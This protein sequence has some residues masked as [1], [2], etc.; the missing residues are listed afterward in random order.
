MN[1]KYKQRGW[2]PDY[3][4]T[5]D[6]WRYGEPIPEWLSDQV[7]IEEISEEGNPIMTE[8]RTNSGYIEIIGSDGTSV[9]VRLRNT[10]S[11]IIY[12]STHP[13]ISLTSHQFEL[14]YEDS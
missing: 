3:P 9:V 2:N 1:L 5:V 7:R 6:V 8:R 13:L 14:L 10:E 11:V 12:S 4:A